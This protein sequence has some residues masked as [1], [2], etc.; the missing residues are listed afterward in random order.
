M[1]ERKH[2]R[3]GSERKKKH[4]TQEK[5]LHMNT[6]NDKHKFVYYDTT[7]FG[8]SEKTCAA[9]PGPLDYNSGIF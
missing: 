6:G 4:N 8:S 9:N 3:T 1:A 2:T 7:D 5:K